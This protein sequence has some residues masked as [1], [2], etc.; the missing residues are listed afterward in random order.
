M[1]QEKENVNEMQRH[2]NEFGTLPPTC[3]A[4]AWLYD[5]FGADGTIQNVDKECS[6]DL[7]VQLT[8]EVLRQCYKSSHSI[9]EVYGNAVVRLVSVKSVF[10][11]F[12]RLR[13]WIGRRGMWR[14][15]PDLLT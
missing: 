1:L 10:I 13:R 8:M 5:R 2:R 14:I 9:Q 12:C 15:H 7:T 4:V 11:T 3:V 6:E